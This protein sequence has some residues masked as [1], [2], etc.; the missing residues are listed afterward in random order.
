MTNQGNQP[1]SRKGEKYIP[2]PREG[3]YQFDEETISEEAFSLPNGEVT[4]RSTLD[5]LID[6]MAALVFTEAS[7]SVSQFGDFQLALSN[8]LVL[9]P[10]YERLMY[11]PNVRGLPWQNTHLWCV[12]YDEA[13]SNLVTE[14]IA[15]HADIPAGQV[16]HHLPENVDGEES[17]RIDCFVVDEETSIPENIQPRYI[18]VVATSVK[19]CEEFAKSC[20]EVQ[21]RGFVLQEN[22]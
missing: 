13:S 22:R 8:T 10:L 6:A 4:V 14:T 12:D 18:I 17:P 21:V 2:Q 15:D 16:H 7:L 20:R 1:R 5:E 11:D 19:S 9:E 3:P